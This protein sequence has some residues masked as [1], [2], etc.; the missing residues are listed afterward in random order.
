MAIGGR[1]QSPEITIID[2]TISGRYC[3]AYKLSQRLK[4]GTEMR[5]ALLGSAAAIAL[6]MAGL[7][8]PAR[9]DQIISFDLSGGLV[10]LDATL[11]VNSANQIV[12][13]SGTFNGETI[14]GLST[15][16]TPPFPT[17]DNLFFPAPTYLDAQG[18][19]F[20]F[21]GGQEQILN[22]APGATPPQFV[23]IGFAT[24]TNPTIFS[25]SVPE[26]ATVG[27]LGVMAAG[28]GLL[29]WRRA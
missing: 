1:G 4:Q 15:S 27:L 24:P 21:V 10:P 12:G 22:T 7:A 23:E 13:I 26:P 20:T 6:G 16:A 2:G 19:A 17:P 29:R 3:P 14:T 8:T 11:V 25:V 5:R 28:L 18:L 9:A